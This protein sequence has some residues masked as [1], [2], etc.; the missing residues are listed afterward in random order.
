MTE[1]TPTTLFNGRRIAVIASVSLLVVAAIALAT[2]PPLRSLASSIVKKEDPKE[3]ELDLAQVRDTLRIALEG[4]LAAYDAA[5]ASRDQRIIAQLNSRDPKVRNAVGMQMQK[6][7][8]QLTHLAPDFAAALILET[9]PF[10]EV[11]LEYGLAAL[12]KYDDQKVKQ[13]LLAAYKQGIRN[14]TV[15]KI[16][17]TRIEDAAT[18][19]AIAAQRNLPES[20]PELL[21]AAAKLVD[22]EREAEEKSQRQST[23]VLSAMLPALLTN[24]YCTVESLESQKEVREICLKEP[25]DVCSV[26]SSVLKQEPQE[27]LGQQDIAIDAISLAGI[28]NADGS[29]LIP[30]L[31]SLKQYSA[32]ANHVIV[33]KAEIR[34]PVKEE[35]LNELKDVALNDEVGY[36]AQRAKRVV[37]ALK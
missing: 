5:Y 1:Q 3:D 30:L 9:D 18:F 28:L 10:A 2:I 12:C 7:R 8:E 15:P 34:P 22:H 23:H 32:F 4:Q 19:I 20:L 35:E 11:G 26:I 17:P 25:E 6:D 29:S 21:E 37:V 13:T 33:A 24:G 36:L 27:L 31:E 14:I 16:N